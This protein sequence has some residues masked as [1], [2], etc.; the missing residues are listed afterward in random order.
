MDRRPI[1]QRLMQALRDDALVDAWIQT[2]NP[3]LNNTPPRLLVDQGRAEE[4]HALIDR[5]IEDMKGN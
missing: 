4:V 5:I 3:A 1:H 2:P